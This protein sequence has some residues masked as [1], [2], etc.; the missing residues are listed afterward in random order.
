[1]KIIV[2]LVNSLFFFLF[3][4]EKGS[5]AIYIHVGWT[6]IFICTLPEGNVNSAALWPDT[7]WRGQDHPNNP[8]T[9]H[10]C[11]MLKCYSDRINTMWGVCRRPWYD[12]D[13]PQ[14]ERETYHSEF[15]RDLAVGDIPCK[16]KAM[17]P[18]KPPLPQRSK[19]SRWKGL[20]RFWR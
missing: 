19:G 5:E 15:G 10:W 8:Q 12:T 9:L 6:T 20:F 4:L 7:A 2:Y 16:V 14:G 11:T 1:M 17:D 3:W 13:I 18:S